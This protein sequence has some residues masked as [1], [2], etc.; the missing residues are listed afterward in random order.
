MEH[1]ISIIFFLRFHKQ[2]KI[3]PKELMIASFSLTPVA[4]CHIKFFV[5]RLMNVK[6]VF[7]AQQMHIA[8]WNVTLAITAF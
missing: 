3:I 5:S 6:Y 1:K 7:L 2:A 8:G 4:D